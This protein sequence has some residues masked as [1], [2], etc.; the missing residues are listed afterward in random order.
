MFDISRERGDP[1]TLKVVTTAGEHLTV[2]PAGALAPTNPVFNKK[3]VAAGGFQYQVKARSM[4]EA[5][6]ILTGLKRKHPEIDIEAELARAE[7]VES[8]PQGA[9][10]HDLTIGGELAGRSIVKSCLAMALAS[11]IDW[12]ACEDAV[13]YLRQDGAPPCFGYYNERDLLSGRVASIPLHC[14]A[15]RADPENGLILAYAEYFGLH[16][17]VACLGE[18][19]TGSLL[20]VVYALDPRQGVELEHYPIILH[21]NR[22]LRSSSCTRLA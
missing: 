17:V 2:G 16:R 14:L 21:H 13:R 20:H 9:V 22:T 6:Q 15:V 19:Y 5:R 11:G 3:T 10:K 7:G 1:P 8:Y 4:E 18:A 12:T